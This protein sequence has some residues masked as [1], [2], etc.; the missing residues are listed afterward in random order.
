MNAFG[1][2]GAGV[3]AFDVVPV[4]VLTF[5]NACLVF[6]LLKSCS[7]LSVYASLAFCIYFFTEQLMSLSES[8]SC[9]LPAVFP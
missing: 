7:N 4:S 6:M 8:Q 2:M 5:W 3:L 9:L 1:S